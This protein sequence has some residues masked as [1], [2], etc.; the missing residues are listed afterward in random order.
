MLFVIQNRNF[1][2]I[3]TV[4]VIV[5]G[6]TVLFTEKDALSFFGSVELGNGYD[7]NPSLLPK[8]KGS[9]FSNLLV[10][11]NQ[12]FGIGEATLL[13]FNVRGN[14]KRYF[15]GESD[16]IT[17]AEA[18]LSFINQRGTFKPSVFLRGTQIRSDFIPED[19]RD[20]A[21]VGLATEYY[22][23]EDFGIQFTFSLGWLDYRRASESVS[24]RS[25]SGTLPNGSGH[26]SPLG[27]M[28]DPKEI[29]I[30][31]A[32]FESIVE[33]KLAQRFMGSGMGLGPLLQGNS[34]ANKDPYRDDRVE[35]LYLSIQKDLLSNTS[36]SIFFNRQRLFSSIKFESFTRYGSGITMT[37]SMPKN[38]DVFTQL[39]WYR[40]SFREKRSRNRV[41]Y[42]KFFSIGLIK[43][44]K[45][46]GLSLKYDYS[47][48][49]SSFVDEYFERNLISFSIGYY[50]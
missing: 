11:L 19:D 16:S 38:F 45:Q 6:T 3:I 29:D 8:G 49:D 12:G 4:F 15:K 5:L 17:E 47:K 22:P 35:Q 37:V 9:G 14:W 20:V 27:G 43:S 50:F 18:N 48:N 44:Y 7:T 2:K 41:D 23:Y 33:K 32:A 10:D 36:V 28:R 42:S 21:T 26:M 34:N 30:L 39:S 46:F 24:G 25:L 31:R 13:T 40:A 1:L